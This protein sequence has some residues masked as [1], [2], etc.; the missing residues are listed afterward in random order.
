MVRS[1]CGMPPTTST[2]QVE[3]AVEVLDGARRAVVAVLREGDELQVDDRARPC[4]F[5]SSSASTREQ[6]V[7]ADVDMGAD[8]EQ[9]LRHR[10]VAIAQ[11]PL[12]HRLMA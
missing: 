11:R 5:T 6:P 10:E 4:C 2:P 8:G 3:R 1:K 7:V 9:A 12:D